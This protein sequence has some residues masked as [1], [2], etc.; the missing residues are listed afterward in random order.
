MSYSSSEC[1][2]LLAILLFSC[3]HG[4]SETELSSQPAGVGFSSIRNGTLDGPDNELEASRDFD[5]FLSIF[6][7]EAFPEFSYQ[8]FHLAGES[9]AGT[10]IPGFVDYIDNRQ[11]LG[12]PDVFPTKIDSI[13]LVDAVIDLLGSG[14]LGQYDHMCQFGKEGNNKLPLGYTRATCRAIG[15]AVPECERLNRQCIE[16]YDGNICSAAFSFC[17]EHID[18][19]LYDGPVTRNPQDDRTVCNGTMPLCGMEQLDRYLNS[20]LVQ[21]ALGTE[22]WN[23][24][25]INFDINA[26]WVDSN[27]IFMPS[28]RELT[29]ILDDT[30]TRVLMLNGNNDILV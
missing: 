16:T 8:P 6:F 23:Y 22:H 28:T 14:A 19:F 30:P 18:Q 29:Y 9:F 3:R 24:T 25:V 7:T 27:E 5:K 26:R 20:P 17:G 21:E 1:H 12:V 15:M 10:Y 2:P 11:R 13:V 4:Y